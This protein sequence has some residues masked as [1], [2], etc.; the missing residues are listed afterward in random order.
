M[1]TPSPATAAAFA[2][3]RLERGAMWSGVLRR[4]HRLRVT[5]VDGGANVGLLLFNRDHLLDRLNLPDTL[6]AQHTVRLTEG[7]VLYSD[8]GHVL[9]SIVADRCGW[10]D[11]LGGHSDVALVRRRLGP[12]SYQEHRNDYFRNARDAFLIELGKWGLGKEALLANLNLFSK[13]VVDDAGTLGFVHGHSTPGATVELR[14][15]VNALAVLNACPH[16]MDPQMVYRPVTLETF[17]G[18]PPSADEPCRNAC[19]ENGRGFQLT[20]ALFS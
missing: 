11:P 5:D 2:P 15:E 12:S 17:P 7:N 13:V 19:P 20:E 4:H 10:H 1:T 9:A 6:K 8:L 16:P 18:P 3:V 14:A